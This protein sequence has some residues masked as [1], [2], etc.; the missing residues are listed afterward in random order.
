MY[1][2]IYIYI[3]IHIYVCVCIL[4]YSE[5]KY[6]YMSDANHPLGRRH[7][8]SL[9]THHSLS[10]VGGA[11]IQSHISPRMLVYEEKNGES[12]VRIPDLALEYHLAECIH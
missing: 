6:Q 10:S 5:K 1:K 3:Y 9:P 7:H 8:G 4:T 12:Q 11:P 2:Y